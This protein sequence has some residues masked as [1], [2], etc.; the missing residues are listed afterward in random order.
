MQAEKL[1]SISLGNNN[2]GPNG[3]LALSKAN[4]DKISIIMFGDNILIKEIIELKT[5]DAIIWPRL[6]GI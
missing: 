1:E 6:D 5:K 3:C 2:I 4:W